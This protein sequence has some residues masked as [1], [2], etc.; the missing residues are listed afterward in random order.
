M[1]STLEVYR[2][3]V[4]GAEAKLFKR[5]SVTDSGSFIVI[6]SLSR[7]ALPRLFFLVG[8]FAVLLIY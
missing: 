7:E 4:I 5:R 1:A 6:W 2:T 3:P 8:T